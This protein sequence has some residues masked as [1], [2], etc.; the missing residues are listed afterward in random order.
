MSDFKAKMHQFNFDRGSAPEPAGGAYN[1]PDL[2]AE[3][4]GPASKAGEGK[5]WEM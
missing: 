1:S 4:N 3:F 2:L 5:E